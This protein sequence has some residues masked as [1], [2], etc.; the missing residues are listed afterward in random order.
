MA[1]PV[2]KALRRELRDGKTVSRVA[3]KRRHGPLALVL[4]DKWVG[5]GIAEQDGDAVAFRLR[6]IPATTSAALDSKLR[7][8]AEAQARAERDAALAAAARRA[9]ERRILAA[10][11]GAAKTDFERRAVVAAIRSESEREALLARGRAALAELGQV[12]VDPALADLFGIE[13]ETA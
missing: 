10:R 8:A 9:E 6:A 13:L 2:E 12:Q 3:A 5:Q 1:G 11:V 4:L 7:L